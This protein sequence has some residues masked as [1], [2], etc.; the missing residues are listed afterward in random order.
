MKTLRKNNWAFTLIE[1]LVVIAII[2]ILAAMLL[3]AL[4]KAKSRAQ[5]ISCVNNQKQITLGMKQWALDNSDRYP[6]AVS[7]DPLGTAAQGGDGG[8]ATIVAG[9]G[10]P[11]KLHG[12]FL[13]M[14]NELNT[15]KVVTCPSDS[16]S[17]ASSWATANAPAG[18]T[19]FTNGISS[20]FVGV[21]AQDAYPQMILIGDRNMGNGATVGQSL[22]FNTM[23]Q[24]GTNTAAVVVQ[25][26]ANWS[27]LLHQ[28]AGNIALSDGSVQQVTRNGLQNALKN[29]G[30]PTAAAAAGNRFLFDSNNRL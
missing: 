30:D 1:L 7:G 13:V 11:A 28:K 4:A 26:W 8:A 2:A 25:T 27:D 10:L 22:H 12:I 20:Y 29:S 3:P 6:M 14:S 21:D 15:P 19:P 24:L 23:T 18:Q 9:V 5:R 16:R 17:P